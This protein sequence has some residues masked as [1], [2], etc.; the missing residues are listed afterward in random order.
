MTN[1]KIQNGC[2]NCKHVFL[3]QEYDKND[4]YYCTKDSPKRPICGSYYLEEHFDP[5]YMSGQ[6]FKWAK[7]AKD[8]GVNGWGI[9]DDWE[10]NV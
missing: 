6:S 8:R 7:W 10:A 3:S 1:Y 4:G 5:Y 9:C 2:H